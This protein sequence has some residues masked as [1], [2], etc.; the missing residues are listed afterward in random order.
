MSVYLLNGPSTAGKTTIG[1]L[2][3]ERGFKVIDTDQAFGHYANFETEKPVDFP[4]SGHPSAEWYKANGWLWDRE[5]VEKAF[6]EIENQTV[7]F[8]GGAYNEHH[9]YPRFTKVFRLHVSPEEFE[10]RI[11]ARGDDPHTNNPNFRKRML[12]FLKTSVQHATAS[13]MIVIDTSNTKPEVSL[14]EILSYVNDK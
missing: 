10:K 3:A 12:D 5:K 1:E 13:G 9:F 7:F 4:S 11:R 14:K 6:Q 2:L 8:C